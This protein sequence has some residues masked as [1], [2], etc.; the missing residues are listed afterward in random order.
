MKATKSM[1]ISVI[2]SESQY[3]GG[4]T[5]KEITDKMEI[6]ES[7][8]YSSVKGLLAEGIISKTDKMIRPVKYKFNREVK[9]EKETK[10]VVG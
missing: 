5:A 2:L 10:G 8:F 9:I 7:A 4:L 3:E 1:A 6:S